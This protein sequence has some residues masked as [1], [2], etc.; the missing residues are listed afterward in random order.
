MKKFFRKLAAVLLAVAIMSVGLPFMAYADPYPLE[1]Y[2]EG[3][4]RYYL[5][6]DGVV[7]F[8][9]TDNSIKELTV[10]EKLGGYNVVA[11]T[12][13][14]FELCTSIEKIT[15]PSSISF[16]GYDSF[17]YTKFYQDKTNWNGNTLSIGDWLIG[18]EYDSTVDSETFNVPNGTKMIAQGTFWN[19]EGISQ[20]NIPAS[21]LNIC[22]YLGDEF[23][24]ESL[25]KI[26]VDE[27]NT[28]YSSDENGILYNKDKSIL[29]RCP[30]ENSIQAFTIPNTVKIIADSAFYGCDNLRS[31]VI[32][33]SVTDI[34]SC[35]FE[36][37]ERL[38]SVSLGKGINEIEDVFGG[39]EYMKDI[40]IPSNVTYIDYYAF[41]YYDSETEEDSPYD[42]LTI[43]CEEGS[44]A[45]NYAVEYGIKYKLLS[46]EHEHDWSFW[47]KES[48]TT[49]YRTCSLCNK[50][51]K[52]S[53]PETPILYL[54]I[55]DETPDYV[56]LMI[57]VEG[58]VNALDTQIFALSEKTKQT[59]VSDD[60]SEFKQYE[61]YLKENELG[62]AGGASNINNG[63]LSC[64]TT[65][66]YNG[67]LI[68]YTFEKNSSEK[69]TK[70]DFN[71]VCSNCC[72][73]EYNDKGEIV[74][75]KV[76]PKIV[77]RL[78][79]KKPQHKHTF[80]YVE[81]PATCT[82]NGMA[83][84]ICEECGETANSEVLYATGHN[85]G[86]W[87]T[88]VEATS[89]TDG[90]A[91]RK[92]SNCNEIEFKTL[93]KINVIKDD[94]TGVEIEYC[95]EFGKNVEIEVEEVFDG[96]SIQLINTEFGNVNTAVFDISTKQDGVKVQPS[97]SVKVR[98]PVPKNF[99][100]GKI[101][102]VYVD[103]EKGT[104]TQIPVE[105]VDGFAEFVVEHFS[106]YALVC[107]KANVK[108]VTMNDIELQ[109]KKQV[110][111]KPEIKCDNGAKYKTEY[112][113]SNSSVVRVD[114]NG[115]L[116][117]AKRGTASVTCTVTD[118]NGNKVSDTC[119]VK[120]KYVWWQWI[121]KIVL[122]GW[123]WY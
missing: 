7:I 95:D 62:I 21:V 109:Y 59:A 117:G 6:D 44:C 34:Q 68:S 31:I 2:T 29:F 88:V 37:C 102:A 12:T 3:I 13:M 52:S 100:S 17:K 123:I 20:I 61:D 71:L 26:V 38:T 79:D 94:K 93:P 30:A 86:D 28:A 41:M 55:V 56:T 80:T 63:K 58:S 54:D 16:I 66:F 51:E 116:Y 4:F 99:G 92:C 74:N 97:G 103:S 40:T 9:C 23:G 98:I 46:S 47:A 24:I 82:V 85:W 122:F 77:N 119:T 106:Y 35:A 96:T 39:C 60:M 45:Y 36:D 5:E 64:I 108:S 83:Y 118:S 78:P 22:G 43:T 120:V 84:E 48:E 91:E 111:L 11:I 8:E 115:N 121:I 70:N 14:A 105:V 114:D 53:I 76:H 110:Q 72:Y 1:N 107:E 104:V 15:L 25:E 18:I 32:P 69:I 50:I 19:C 42:Y 33:D 65:S 75:I 89:E 27:K 49:I 57:S 112:K 113:S 81:I 90:K 87:V 73:T 67:P 101:F 10:P